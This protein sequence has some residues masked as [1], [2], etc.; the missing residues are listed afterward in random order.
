MAREAGV[1][2]RKERANQVGHQRP[3][4]L[5]DNCHQ[6][7]E[8][9][10]Q[11][12]RQA[13]SRLSLGWG[14]TANGGQVQGCLGYCMLTHCKWRTWHARDRS[15]KHLQLPTDK[16]D[17][18][19]FNAAT[20]II[21][22]N[23]RKAS[24]WNSRW[25][26]NGVL[27]DLFPSLYKH[28]RRKNRTVAEALTLNTWVRDVD[29]SLTQSLIAEFLALWEML[30]DIHLHEE[31]EDRIVWRFTSDGQYTARSAYN[32][33]FEDLTRCAPAELTWTAKAP[34]KCRFFCWLMLR[35][36]IWTPARLQLRQWP[37]HYF[38][39]LCFRSLET[40]CHLFMECPVSRTL[41]TQIAVWATIP[42][43]L[44][45]EWV[46]ADTLKDWFLNMVTAA[47]RA[48]RQ[49][50]ISLYMLVCWEIWCERNRRIFR[51][52]YK[53]VPHVLSLILD[54]A[55]LWAYAGNKGLRRI[56]LQRAPADEH[57]FAPAIAIE[58]AQH[59]LT[60]N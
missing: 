43:L 20:K 37:N 59:V 46:T 24:F 25:L 56:R 32:A 6:A 5:S 7:A 41:W 55:A 19:L 11:G 47:P 14:W 39:Q 53:T 28:S 13:T 10:H 2:C 58:E 4:R 23:G 9:V 35:N 48:S 33:Q 60:V 49:A 15:W 38:C 50:A 34:P 54:E 17:L 29:H 3:A 51:S 36:R 26:Q 31:R 8:E 30:E 44:P 45:D 27:S 1:G 40:T 22:G 18:Q 52:Q 12:I 21:L 16:M 42:S 57:H